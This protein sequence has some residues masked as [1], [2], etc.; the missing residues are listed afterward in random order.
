MAQNSNAIATKQSVQTVR[1]LLERSRAAFE[2]VLPKHMDPNRLLRIALS[3]V[4]RTPKLMACDS[5]TLLLSIMNAALA[6]LEPNTPLYEGW[7]IPFNNRKSGTVECQFIPGYRG[8]LK[9][10][11]NSGEVASIIAR[12]VYE[13]DKFDVSF[14]TKTAITHIPV[15]DGDRGKVRLVYAIGR[16]KDPG[17][18]PYVEI[19]TLDEIKAISKRSA[20]YN[21][22]KQVHYG[23]WAT[24]F[25][26]MALKTVIRR[27]C[28][29]MPASV[30]MAS[31][32][33]L[34]DRAQAGKTQVDLAP[35]GVLEALELEAPVDVDEG[36]GEVN[37]EGAL[38]EEQMKPG[39]ASKHQGHELP[40]DD[41]V[42]GGS[43]D[44]P[45]QT[46]AEF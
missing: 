7:L 29:Y 24:D 46:E 35:S 14:G 36:T 6:G 23:P 2:A 25:N 12:L 32:L 28:K 9:I 27:I 11:R 4:T 44:P 31:A 17:A 15:L 1:D 34:D 37:S 16:L 40:K 30:E 19:M 20:S 13:K 3:A 38:S 45:G 33:E 41:K 39:D 43:G 26:Q 8:L 42:D 21:K 22:S 18:D 5:R 10:A